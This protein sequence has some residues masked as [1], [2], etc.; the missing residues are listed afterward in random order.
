MRRYVIAAVTLL[1]VVALF[2]QENIVPKGAINGAVQRALAGPVIP[3]F[4]P[5][6]VNPQKPRFFS[7]PSSG[8]N[9]C[10]I[11]LLEAK[12][13]PT[14]DRIAA[15]GGSRTLDSGM[16]KAPAIPACPSR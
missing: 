2:G 10:A 16:A 6:T 14:H 13:K 4:R 12:V 9:I 3:G 15:K 8:P 5:G 7:L 11:P 1:S